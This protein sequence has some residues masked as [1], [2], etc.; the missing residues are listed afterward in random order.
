MFQVLW[1]K[2]D[3]EPNLNSGL[4]SLL[5]AAEFQVIPAQEEETNTNKK[6][7]TT[8]ELPKLNVADNVQEVPPLLGKNLLPSMAPERIDKE[9]MKRYIHAGQGRGD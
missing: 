2:M 1:F 5:V 8:T 9:P 4:I 3:D 6:E 7:P